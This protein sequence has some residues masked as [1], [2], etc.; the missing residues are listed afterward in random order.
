MGTYCKGVV[1]KNGNKILAGRY[2]YRNIDN[3]EKLFCLRQQD[4]SNFREKDLELVGETLVAPR[5]G[6]KDRYLVIS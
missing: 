3:I 4:N 5:G 6:G 1:H 2:L